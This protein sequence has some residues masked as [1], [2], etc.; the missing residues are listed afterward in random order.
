MTT[1]RYMCGCENVAGTCVCS[2]VC[3]MQNAHYQAFYTTPPHRTVLPHYTHTYSA[4]P[5]TMRGTRSSV[6]T[7]RRKWK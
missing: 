1:A 2:E 4:L 5:P 7:L 6:A 3:V